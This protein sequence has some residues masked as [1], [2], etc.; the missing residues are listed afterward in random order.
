[1][2]RSGD[3]IWELLNRGFSDAWVKLSRNGDVPVS[4]ADALTCDPQTSAPDCEIV[5]KV[6]F[7]DNGFVGLDVVYHLLRQDDN[8]S[9]GLRLSDHPPLQTDFV[10]STPADR[11][12]SDPFGGPHGTHFNDV[13]VLPQNP[14]VSGVNI[15]AG[16]RVDR[17]DLTL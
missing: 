14:A 3:N 4:G 8:P 16:S 11:R 2:T 17:I 6:L 9:D 15:R 5:D 10:Y 12:L 7:R 1:Y 13:A